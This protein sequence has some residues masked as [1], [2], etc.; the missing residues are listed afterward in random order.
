MNFSVVVPVSARPAYAHA[1]IESLV[2]SVPEGSEIV[3]VDNGSPLDTQAVINSFADKIKIVKIDDNKGTAAGYNAG[4]RAAKN[5]LL[6]LLHSDCVVPSDWASAIPSCAQAMSCSQIKVMTPLTNYADEGTFLYS[7]ELQQ[8]F[9]KHKLTN[10]K[11]PTVDEV[12]AI[13][14]STYA[15]VGGMDA[16]SKTPMP[17]RDNCSE[18]GSFC[19]VLS[20]STIDDVGD[21]DESFKGRGYEDKEF[22]LRLQL[23]GYSAGVAPFFVHHFGNITSD[24]PGMNCHKMREENKPVYDSL[25]KMYSSIDSRS[26]QRKWSCIVYPDVKPEFTTRLLKNIGELSHSPE[27]IVCVPAPGIFPERKALEWALPQVTTEFVALMDSDFLFDKNMPEVMLGY[28]S[29]PR[30]G[31]VAALMRCRVNGSAG[32]Y[33]IWRTSVLKQITFSND[34]IRDVTPDTDYIDACSKAGFKFLRI[35][36]VVGDHAIAMEPFNIFKIYFRVG[37]KQRARGRI[38]TPAQLWGVDGAMGTNTPWSHLA[39]FAFHCG[40]QVD[41][42]DD[43]HTREWEDFAYQHYLKVKPFCEAL[44]AEAV[45]PAVRSPE[46]RGDKVKVMLASSSFATGGCERIMLNMSLFL[47]KSRFE[48]VI[49]YESGS[50]PSFVAAAGE[51]GVQVIEV[52]SRE[53]R[54]WSRVLHSERPDIIVTFLRCGVF[55]PAKDLGI[56]LVERT[57]GW[58]GHS[59]VTKDNFERVVCEYERFRNELLAKPEMKPVPEKTEVLYNGVNAGDFARMTIPEARAITG[60]R[61]SAFA[62]VSVARL[63]PKKNFSL[64][65]QAMRG[66]VD[67]GV[68]AELHIVGRHSQPHEAEEKA[69]LDALVSKLGLGSRV[70]F[71]G[72][73]P[74]PA[75]FL[76]SADVVT[77]SSNEEGAPNI[78]VEAMALGK[79]IVSTDVGGVREITEGLASYVSSP[80]EFAAAI[81]KSK[82]GALV[83]YPSFSKRFS[84]ESCMKRWGEILE[85]VYLKGHDR[86]PYSGERK[87]NVAL[88]CE[89][90]EIGGMETFVRTFDSIVDRSKFKVFVYSHVGG[91]L[92]A[93]LRSKVRLC[94]GPWEV[95]DNKMARWLREDDIDVAIV[96]TYSRAAKVFAIS[97]P[98]KV[99]ERLDGAHIELVANK[100]D[101]DIVVFQSEILAQQQR[102]KYDGMRHEIVSNGRDLRSYRRVADLRKSFRGRHGV[103]DNVVVFASVGRIDHQKNFV[104]LADVSSRLLKA[105]HDRFRFFVMGPDEGGRAMLEAR[106]RELGVESRLTVLDGGI[107]SVQSLLSAADVFVHPSLKEG[108]AGVLIEAAAAGLPIIASDVGATRDVVGDDNGFVVPAGDAE[109]MTRAVVALMPPGNRMRLGEASLAKAEKFDAH[110][111]V[112]KFEQFASELAAAKRADERNTPMVTVVTPVYDRAEYLDEAIKSVIGQTNPNWRMIIAMDTLEPCQAILDV[113]EANK[114][115]RISATKCSHLNQCSAIN[116]AARHVRTPYVLRLDSDDLLTEDAIEEVSEAIRLSPE[117]GYFYSSYTT[118]DGESKPIPFH[119]RPAT[120]MAEEFSPARLEEWNIAVPGVVW[121]NSEFLAVGGFAEDVPYGE[122]YLLPLMMMLNGTKFKAISKPY[123]RY[124]IHAAGNICSRYDA[125][126]QEFFIQTVRRRYTRAKT[127]M[128]KSWAGE[129]PRCMRSR[130]MKR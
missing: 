99:I 53:A 60:I 4:I 51:A 122:D 76:N 116:H 75:D 66:I 126:E 72:S 110:V 113:L 78:L 90:L 11:E 6:V 12:R 106:T 119:G 56:P 14:A 39:L 63:H 43:P 69:R 23:R 38:G 118:I 80:E 114:D 27:K 35:G 36:N 89:C 7:R 98:C 82:P 87:T 44:V 109:E 10:K 54:A 20:R 30:V 1:C 19:M 61:P 21:F 104:Q 94:P 32:Y 127:M 2:A 37:V 95:A 100:A 125:N 55:G 15:H 130:T 68:D 3:V 79:P 48:P 123:F 22:F 77:L 5:E 34:R 102:E 42:L 111:M 88:L 8:E 83:E 81:L 59:G 18:L 71:H 115:P 50:D 86:L 120:R 91:P 24:G 41:C 45:A 49:A 28:F 33:R 17:Q 97:K 85:E 121:K 40:I 103:A 31:C 52:G 13:V 129:D 62:I 84:M 25:F 74:R 16:F 26:S 58:G 93:A 124:R 46:A 107:D 101:T 112:K 108:L 29:D 67:A 128:N 65:I 47:D 92:E 64:Q 105:G 96:V 9:L 70:F 73:S 117:V 57:P